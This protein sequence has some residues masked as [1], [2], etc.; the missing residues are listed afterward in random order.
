MK[1]LKLS[2]IIL[3]SLMVSFSAFADHGTG[4]IGGSINRFGQNCDDLPD[5]DF[6]AS[7]RNQ[8]QL[9]QFRQTYG[10]DDIISPGSIDGGGDIG[11]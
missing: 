2:L 11:G 5:Q 1:C 10:D 4:T 7:C 9:D 6:S 8:Q 3:F